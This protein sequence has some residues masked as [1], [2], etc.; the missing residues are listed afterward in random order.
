MTLLLLLPIL[1][2][3][4][5]FKYTQIFKNLQD[6]SLKFLEVVYVMLFHLFCF[7]FSPC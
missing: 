5:L 3:Q 1:P 2:V 6:L 7:N 4:L